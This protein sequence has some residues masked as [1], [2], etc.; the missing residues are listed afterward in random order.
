MLRVFL[1]IATIFGLVAVLCAFATF[2]R[3]P[4]VRR[5]AT[6]AIYGS[7][8]AA[9]ISAALG[10]WFSH[11]QRVTPLP[12]PNKLGTQTSRGALSDAVS[13]V[14]RAS[15]PVG[16]AANKWVLIRKGHR[17]RPLLVAGQSHSGTNYNAGSDDS[18]PAPDSPYVK[19]DS[20]K[21]PRKPDNLDGS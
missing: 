18:G 4:T 12:P 19:A 13:T 3:S 1:L 7:L 2:S 9:V 5:T 16:D 8:A 11:R 10:A 6:R 17:R 20:A 15:A 14:S 21:A